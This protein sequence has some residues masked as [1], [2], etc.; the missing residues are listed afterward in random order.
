MPDRLDVTVDSP[1]AGRRVLVAAAD[2]VSQHLARRLLE[3]QGLE[4][5]LARTAAEALDVAARERLDLV[6]VDAALLEPDAGGA[7]LAR[8]VGA[9]A[10]SAPPPVVV[11]ARDDASPD[12]T[13]RW[14]AAGVRR[15]LAK[16][17]RR[18]G[19]DEL[20]DALDREARGGAPA[21]RRAGADHAPDDDARVAA[22]LRLADGDMELVRILGHEYLRQ[23][24]RLL[25]E[26]RAAVHDA[27]AERVRRAAH[28][29]KGSSAQFGASD[30]A[31]LALA[32]EHAGAERRLDGAAGSLDAVER[33]VDGLRRVLERVVAGGAVGSHS[34]SA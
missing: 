23:S 25:A 7:E 20:L 15:R 30:V 21:D 9:R 33:A 4:V 29:L 17:L 27:D 22:M 16:P 1:W 10:G 12:A 6:V 3:A 18:E 31:R 34:P 24:P 19:L 13:A 26:L 5:L 11:L 28:T 8:H 2:T 32:L 14:E